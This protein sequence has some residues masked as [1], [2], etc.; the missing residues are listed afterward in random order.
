[1]PMPVSIIQRDIKLKC[2]PTNGLQ[3]YNLLI[4][5]INEEVDE[6]QTILSELSD[7]EAKQ[8]FIKEWNPHIRSVSVRD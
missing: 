1:M 7:S 5:A 4:E 6:L 3:A 8:C 2:K